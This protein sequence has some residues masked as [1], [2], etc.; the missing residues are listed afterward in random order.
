LKL[1][2]AAISK[3]AKA[4]PMPCHIHRDEGALIRPLANS[5]RRRQLRPNAK[6]IRQFGNLPPDFFEPTEDD[7]GEENSSSR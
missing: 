5:D 1:R 7:D 4:V 2:W 6:I 3:E